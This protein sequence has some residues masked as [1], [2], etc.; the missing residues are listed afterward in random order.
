[1]H[2]WKKLVQKNQKEERE[3]KVDRAVTVVGRGVHVVDPDRIQEVEE[4]LMMTEGIEEDS[5]VG[6]LVGED[7][8]E[9]VKTQKKV[10]VLEFLE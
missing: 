10:N 6:L 7:T 4:I 3:A 9:I 1:M 5:I 8:S 2:M